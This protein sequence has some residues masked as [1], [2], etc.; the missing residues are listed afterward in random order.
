MSFEATG[1][2]AAS[3]HESHEHPQALLLNE[4][5]ANRS[6]R[7]ESNTDKISEKPTAEHEKLLASAKSAFDHFPELKNGGIDPQTIAAIILR[8]QQHRSAHNIKESVL[9]TAVK[10]QSIL[11]AG[12][13][14]AA[15]AA[16]DVGGAAIVCN[17]I[18]LLPADASIGPAQMQIRTIN[19]VKD[20]SRKTYGAKD[21][22]TDVHVD[23]SALKVDN[24]ALLVAAL[25]AKN[26]QSFNCGMFRNA[27]KGKDMENVHE[28]WKQGRKEEAL[29]VAYNPGDCN[30]YYPWK[31]HPSGA[32]YDGEKYVGSVIDM[33]KQL[34]SR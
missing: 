20:W 8:E 19:R 3:T 24:A 5:Y 7:M 13:C 22:L 34:S 28:L 26:I 10:H 25:L 9:E 6:T 31:P 23:E 30:Y 12:E 27:E 33:K 32:K 29:I 1:M 16:G 14:I 21:P 11:A 4:C 2:F 15:T 18:A 17:G